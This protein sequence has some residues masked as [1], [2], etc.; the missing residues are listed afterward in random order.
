[1]LLAVAETK[2]RRTVESLVQ[3]HWSDP[4]RDSTARHQT[5][6]AELPQLQVDDVETVAQNRKVTAV[7]PVEVYYTSSALDIGCIVV[8]SEYPKETLAGI[9]M[10]CLAAVARIAAALAR[11]RMQ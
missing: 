3:G 9:A 1:M 10:M 5:D 4:P 8:F 2:S 7:E 11:I 6:W